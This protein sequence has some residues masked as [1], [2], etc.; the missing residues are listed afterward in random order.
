MSVNPHVCKKWYR[1]TLSYNF[2]VVMWGIKRKVGLVFPKPVSVLTSAAK[3]KGW[4]VVIF[5]TDSFS[6]PIEKSEKKNQ[7]LLDGWDQPVSPTTFLSGSILIAIYL[8][9][10][11]YWVF[12]TCN[13]GGLDF[14]LYMFVSSSGDMSIGNIPEIANSE[15]SGTILKPEHTITLFFCRPHLVYMQRCSSK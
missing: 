14:I 1:S 5:F 15:S 7:P 11:P 3:E 13:R 12:F 8:R 10:S 9:I 6:I 4:K 2:N